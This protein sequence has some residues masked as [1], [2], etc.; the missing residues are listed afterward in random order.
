M[1]RLLSR[2]EPNLRALRPQLGQD[3]DATGAKAERLLGWRPRPIERT[4][5][6]TADSLLA[7]GVLRGG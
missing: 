4:L 6:D 5:A 1:A 7:H 3:F 2:F